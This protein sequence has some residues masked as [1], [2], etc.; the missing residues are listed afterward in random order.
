MDFKDLA[1]NFLSSLIIVLRRFILLIFSPY[2]TMRKISKDKD[3]SQVFIIFI[4]VFLYFKFIYYLRSNPY[5][6]T[7]I[8]LIFIF[9][10][11]V[12]TLFFYILGKFSD[13]NIEL[14]SFIFTFAYS[15]LPTI[16][17]FVVSSILYLILPPPRTFSPQGLG[18]SIFYIAFS[19]SLLAWKIILWYLSLRFSTRL[20]FYRITYMLFLFLLWVL[21]Y[22]LL[23]YHFKIFRIPFI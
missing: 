13:Q 5:P 20:G 23:L 14:S 19:I 6:A 4:L 1:V 21:P 2:K 9:N 3:Y 16:I 8:F 22:S 11:L 18:F 10:F 15:L 7:I 12:T 17:W